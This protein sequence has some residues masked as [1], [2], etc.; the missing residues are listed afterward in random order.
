MNVFLIRLLNKIKLLKYFNLSGKLVLNKIEFKIPIIERTGFENLF[1]SEPWMIDLLKIVLKNDDQYF[2]DVGVN[3]GQTLLKLKSVSGKIK[4]I[5]FEPNPLCV[6]YVNKL[7]KEN[8]FENCQLIPTG[9]SDSTELGVLN[10]FN[11]STTDSSA[12]IISNFRVNQNIVRREYIPIFQIDEIKNKIDLKNISV[13]KV[14]VEGAELQ[15]LKSFHSLIKQCRP[16]ILIEILPTY[17]ESNSS[18][19]ERQNEIVQI[20]TNLN[21]SIYR[22]IK[23]Q[24]KFIQLLKISTIEIHSDLNQCEYVM[25]PNDKTEIIKNYC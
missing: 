17:N 23:K 11:N 25:I 16:I 18:R 13:L 8:K 3:V 9:V 10:F 4:Y 12:S 5:G 1:I 2:V 14:D 19:I 20:V 7:I 22:V 6:F 24:Y 15:V 21:Y